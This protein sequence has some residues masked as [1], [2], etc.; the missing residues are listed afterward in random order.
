VA[1]IAAQIGGDARGY[2]IALCN[3]VISLGGPRRADRAYGRLACCVALLG[4]AYG[5]FAACAVTTVKVLST[6]SSPAI[7]VS[8]AEM[9]SAAVDSPDR[10]AAAVDHAD[11]IMGQGS[12]CSAAAA[13]RSAFSASATRVSA[14]TSTD[15]L[16][17]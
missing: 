15:R 2:G 8:A 13:S 5:R 1:R 14:A 16:K 3:G 17:M 4:R 11:R 7:R 10:F 6:G 12:L 9:A